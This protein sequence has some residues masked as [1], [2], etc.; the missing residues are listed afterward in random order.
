[1]AQPF[2][3]TRPCGSGYA[4][5]ELF[6]PPA[7]ASPAEPAEFDWDRR[8]VVVV[9]DSGVLMHTVCT[10]SAQ[11]PSQGKPLYGR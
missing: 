3:P 9:G 2:T 8:D 5:L 4:Q 6:T 1:M 11:A 7:E 10:P